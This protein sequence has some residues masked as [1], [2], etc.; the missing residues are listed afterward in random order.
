MKENL[1]RYLRR[2]NIPKKIQRKIFKA[3]W[4]GEE[5]IVYSPTETDYIDR[6]INFEAE[7]CEYIEMDYLQKYFDK[8]WQNVILP[9]YKSDRRIP[10]EKS[11]NESETMNSKV[12][13]RF[14]FKSKPIPNVILEFIRLFLAQR[15]FDEGSFM[16]RGKWSLK[17]FASKMFFKGDL[18]SQLKEE[19]KKKWRMKFYNSNIRP[20]E[21]KFVTSKEGNLTLP[22]RPVVAKKP[23]QRKGPQGART[24]PRPKSSVNSTRRKDKDDIDIHT[25]S[26]SESDDGMN[27]MKSSAMPKPAEV[28]SVKKNTNATKVVLDE[29]SEAEILCE[30]FSSDDEEISKP[31]SV[32]KT[33][34]GRTIRMP[35]RYE[36]TPES[37]KRPK[38]NQRSKYKTIPSRARVTIRQNNESSSDVSDED[39]VNIFGGK[40]THLKT[41][42]KCRISKNKHQK[43][44]ILES[45]SEEFSG[46]KKAQHSS[47][48][49]LN[50]SVNGSD[51]LMFQYKTPLKTP[52]GDNSDDSTESY[53]THYMKGL[54]SRQEEIR[55]EKQWKEYRE[56]ALAPEPTL[57]FKTPDEYTPSKEFDDVGDF[58]EIIE[59]FENMEQRF[60]ASDRL[61]K[62]KASD[63]VNRQLDLLRDRAFEEAPWPGV[64]EKH[65]EQESK[66]DESRGSDI[67]N[68]DDSF[69]SDIIEE[70]DEIKKRKNRKRNFNVDSDD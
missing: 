10:L 26:T 46:K 42:M 3:V 21:P 39:K 17:P 54:R 8:V 35:K 53:W 66:S 55:K 19:D 69:V 65:H 37:V 63:Y 32:R 49:S 20:T 28:K 41:P 48:D 16:G 25:Q 70:E 68:L 7:F 34:R 44:S 50:M 2:Q 57:T 13:S 12:R 9:H 5:S 29:E 38:S 40:D 23:S 1:I 47:S 18:F 67:L 45:D 51:D 52:K 22:K 6:R 58:S 33:R 59:V 56:T 24:I 36:S 14:H 64:G 60:K 43:D 62:K 15:N 4:K 61:R 30:N 27:G 11:N 31:D